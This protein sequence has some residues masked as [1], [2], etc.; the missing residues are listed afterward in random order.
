MNKFEHIKMPSLEEA[1]KAVN[2]T[3]EYFNLNQVS[4]SYF[5][6][7]LLSTYNSNGVER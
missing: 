1:K 6:D 5:T 4:P 3:M 7:A 2:E